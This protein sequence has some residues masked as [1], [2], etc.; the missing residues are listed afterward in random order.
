MK[1]GPHGKDYS[2]LQISSVLHAYATLLN[3]LPTFSIFVL[4]YLFFFH[5]IAVVITQTQCEVYL[6]NISF[7][8]HIFPIMQHKQSISLGR[9][10]E[11]KDGTKKPAM[12]K[13]AVSGNVVCDRETKKRSDSQ[14]WRPC[15]STIYFLIRLFSLN[16][17]ARW[18]S[19]KTQPA[20]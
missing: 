18:S 11:V 7:Q 14:L 15:I 12:R 17:S 9:F 13:K 6:P 4:T 16:I 19:L 20:R 3:F 1:E 2:K 10:K 5:F 8:K